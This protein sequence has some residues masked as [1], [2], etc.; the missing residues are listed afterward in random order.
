MYLLLFF[1]AILFPM[2]IRGQEAIWVENVKTAVEISSEKS[3][4]LLIVFLGPEKCP[5]SQKMEGDV[6]N[7]PAFKEALSEDFV[8]LK[9]WDKQ[10]AKKY[11]VTELPSMVIID[12]HGEVVSKIAYLPLSAQDFTAYIKE[13]F[14]DF[15]LIKMSSSNHYMK[16]MPF[17]QLKTLFQKVNRLENPH[18]KELI[19][20]EGLKKDKGAFFLVQQYMSLIE[21]EK[22]KDRKIQRLRKQILDRDP[23]NEHGTHLKIALID[24]QVLSKKSKPHKAIKPLLEYT[25]KF[26]K[27]DRDNVWKMEMM[28]AQFLFSHSLIKEALFHADLSL[29]E[30]PEKEKAEVSQ[31]IE[32]FK[33][34]S[35]K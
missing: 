11:H 19:L 5:W 1:A 31:S 6:L 29:K 25:Q 18:F 32:Y 8:L 15:Q 2:A 27:Q 13:V 7:D 21:K 24:F 22:I 9:V 20:Q 3:K 17:E 34:H 4:P 16:H 10:L 35:I 14:F 30:A 28:M 12:S 33:S 23:K 26:G